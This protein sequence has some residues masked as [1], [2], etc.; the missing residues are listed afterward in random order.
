MESAL[1]LDKFRVCA[2]LA[3]DSPSFLKTLSTVIE[4]LKS[5]RRV[6]D[7]CQKIDQDLFMR[8][9]L[10]AHESKKAVYFGEGI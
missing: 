8:Q 10:A 9:L 2:Y 6:I 4:E 1:N 3:S 5:A 7:H